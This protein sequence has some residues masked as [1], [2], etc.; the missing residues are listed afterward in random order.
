MGKFYFSVAT[1]MIILCMVSCYRDDLVLQ[2]DPNVNDDPLT[3]SNDFLARDNHV[4]MVMHKI[5]P[6]RAMQIANEAPALFEPNRRKARTIPKHALQIIPIVDNVR[7]LARL[8]G[9]APIH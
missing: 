6:E 4:K 2:N 8:A 1:A 3:K 9:G 5:T 7:S